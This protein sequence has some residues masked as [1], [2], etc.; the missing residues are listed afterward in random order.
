MFSSYYT[1]PS[2]L[3]SQSSD[4][5]LEVKLNAYLNFVPDPAIA[6]NPY[7]FWSINEASFPD[8]A[9]LAESYL[10]FK[11]GEASCEGVFSMSAATIGSRRTNLSPKLVEIL[12]FIRKNKA[13]LLDYWHNRGKQLS[14]IVISHEELRAYRVASKIREMESAASVDAIINSTDAVELQADP[15]EQDEIA[16]MFN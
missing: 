16:A 1:P 6:A 15:V 8:M 14:D 13:A 12:T 11:S 4:Q 7:R 10:S 5:T 3:S 9:E 2:S